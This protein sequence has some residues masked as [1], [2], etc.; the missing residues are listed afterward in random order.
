MSPDSHSEQEGLQ[1]LLNSYITAA[2][3]YGYCRDLLRSPEWA[4]YQYYQGMTALSRPGKGDVRMSPGSMLEWWLTLALVIMS[5]QMLALMQR[6]E[7]LEHL[8][9]VALRDGLDL[10]RGG[11]VATNLLEGALSLP[12]YSGYQGSVDPFTIDG[13]SRRRIAP[14]FG[15]A[16]HERSRR[17][18]PKE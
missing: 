17:Y 9:K 6:P 5:A 16:Y 7:E 14:L 10:A 1:A 8:Q 3:R 12:G 11:E 13:R 18:V 4:I 2:N 15:L